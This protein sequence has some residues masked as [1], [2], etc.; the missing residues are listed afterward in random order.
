MT[1]NSKRI[2]EEKVWMK[3]YTEEAR[4]AQSPKMKAFEYVMALNK[5]RMN[6]TAIHYYG[7][8][9]SFKELRY[10][11]DSA[12]R[13]FTALGVKPGDIVSFLSVSIPETIAAVYIAHQVADA[14]NLSYETLGL[15]GDADGNGVVNANDAELV[16]QYY[17]LLIDSTELNL[18]VCDVNGD[19]VINATDAEL[20][21]QYYARVIDA[22]PVER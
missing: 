10:R 14:L 1:G 5:H 19:G 13:A 6:D 11:V 7:T 15:W 2:T 18:A 9:I 21:L 16:L 4:N 22:F 17:A 20:I 12:A 8:D 3:Y